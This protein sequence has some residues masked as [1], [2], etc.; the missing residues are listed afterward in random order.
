MSAIDIKHNITIDRHS[1]EVK[2]I[3][4]ALTD[5]YKLKAKFEQLKESNDKDALMKLAYFRIFDLEA[6]KAYQLALSYGGKGTVTNGFACSQK[7]YILEAAY[8]LKAAGRKGFTAVGYLKGLFDNYPDEA[9]LLG[10]RTSY[11]L[12]LNASYSEIYKQSNR[13]RNV[14]ERFCPGEYNA[15]DAFTEAFVN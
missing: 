15:T 2:E 9:S 3:N 4:E 11:P 12:F 8:N 10:I 5:F 13:E 7:T 14:I 6:N 1:H